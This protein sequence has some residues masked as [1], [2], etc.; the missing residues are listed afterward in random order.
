MKKLL[1]VVI[2]LVGILANSFAQTISLDDLLNLQKADLGK[3]KKFCE[4]KQL[5]PH[6]KPG[7]RYEVVEAD[8]YLFKFSDNL[9][10][11][12]SNTDC[13]NIVS[14]PGHS[15]IIAY[16]TN[17]NERESALE[18]QVALKAKPAISK[19]NDG[20]TIRS[21]TFNGTQVTFNDLIA[22]SEWD[23]QHLKT[24]VTIYNIA[25]L[26]LRK[27]EFCSLCKGKG[28]LIEHAK[29]TRCD[30]TGHKRCF[31]CNA[32]GQK[33]CN[34]CIEGKEICSACYG[35]GGSVCEVCKGKVTYMCKYCGG[36]G[37]EKCPEC[38]GIGSISR[39]VP[40][41][42]M[43]TSKCKKCDGTGLR[44]CRGCAGTGKITCTACTNGKV[45]CSV[46]NGSGTTGNV[47]THCNGN[48]ATTCK[49]CAGTGHTEEVCSYCNGTALNPE[50]IKSLCPACKGDGLNHSN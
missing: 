29:C 37:K 22:F 39:N 42:G 20:R 27:K 19:L 49:R 25:D 30:S 6:S 45:L 18:K 8:G 36:G 5:I 21:Y 11:L 7:K 2:G 4:Y 33:T 13:I 1:L 46:C 26:A 44:E 50:E 48:Y 35:Q 14:T 38:M 9:Y 28:V 24:V 31:D 3:V 12:N 34:Y 15:N 40:Y 16:V 43:V 23:E 10:D 17:S 32:T 41:A 47:C